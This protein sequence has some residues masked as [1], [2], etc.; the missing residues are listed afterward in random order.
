MSLPKPAPGTFKWWIIGTIGIGGGIA[1]A[2][3]FGLSASLGVPTWE[4]LSS[5]VVNDQT[6]TVRF[7]VTRPSGQPIT[8][9]VRALAK[10][11]ATVGSIEVKVPQADGDTSEESVTFR[12]TTRAVA[13]EVRT[14]ALP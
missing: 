10:D 6:I 9:Q 8:C 7:Q 1:M 11:F 12:T 2:I 5:K 4:T 3:W 13:G 14:C